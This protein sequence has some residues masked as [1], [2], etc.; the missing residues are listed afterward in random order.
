MLILL[1]KI[2]SQIWYIQNFKNLNCYVNIYLDKKERKLFRV[3]LYNNSN[4]NTNY[5]TYDGHSQTTFVE[6][7]FKSLLAVIKRLIVKM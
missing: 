3:N 1:H 2:H 7:I 6:A 4:Y 5:K